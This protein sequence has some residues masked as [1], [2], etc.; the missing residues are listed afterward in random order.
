MLK[1]EDEKEVQI[2]NPNVL[3]EIGAA[4]ALYG[5]RFIL[6][7][8][9]G[10]KLPSNLQGL[11]EVRYS[12]EKLDAND[13]FKLLDAMQDVRTTLFPIVIKSKE[14]GRSSLKSACVY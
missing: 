11:Y 7:I 14:L 8:R 4:Q 5:R 13:A 6:L 1:D 3:T 10:V 2:L 12:G 9:D